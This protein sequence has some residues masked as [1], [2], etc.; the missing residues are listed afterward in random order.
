MIIATA[1]H[2]D[3]GKTTLIKALTGVNADRLAEE[4]RRGMTI[5][6]GFAYGRRN[7]LDL[8]FV[9]VPGHE[10]FIRNML[11]GV[12]GVDA[13][14]LVVAADD[15]VMPQTREHLEIIDLLGLDQGV[16]A[17]TKADMVDAER[18]S[19]V[20]QEVASLLAPTGLH[21]IPIEPV[22]GITGLGLD[23]LTEHLRLLAPETSLQSANRAFRLAVDRVFT[24]D[25][26][27]L[28]A[29][30][31]AHSGQVSVGDSLRVMPSG[32][33]VRVRSLRAHNQPVTSAGR[34][35]RIAINLAG[36]D[37][38]EVGRGDWLVAAHLDLTTDRLDVRLRATQPLRHWDAIRFCHGA[39]VHEGRLA[40][41]ETK[42]VTPGETALAQLVLENPIQAVHGDRFVLRNASNIATIAGGVVIDPFSPKRGRA[43]PERL[44]LVR[45]LADADL[46]DGAIAEL[47][48]TRNG[49]D[50]TPYAVGRGASIDM[51]EQLAAALPAVSIGTG[52]ID[53]DRWTLL[54][55]EITDFLG[56]H[57]QDH[58][59]K[60]GAGRAELA[61]IG[62][63][64]G[65]SGP[66]FEGVIN[67]LVSNR[68]LG[69][70]GSAIALAGHKPMLAPADQKLWKK[71]E[72]LFVQAGLR[73]PRVR[74][75]AEEL[76]LDP[77]VTERFLNRCVGAGLLLKVADNRYFPPALLNRL[78]QIAGELD[79]ETQGAF[80]V[81]DYKDRSEIG[82]NLTIELLE[83]FDRAGLTHRSGETR[84]LKRS[85]EELFPI[86]SNTGI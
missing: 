39:A 86:G 84:R 32:A 51:Q 62:K 82:R 76:S 59:D 8:A 41:L 50:L 23:E 55:T 9:D 43:K 24:I 58:P 35:E 81:R 65:L 49:F 6:L 29:T 42:A 68:H 21:N 40:L 44:A 78:G 33:L 30:G 38:D 63:S 34:G 26:A 36:V 48:A 83:F 3:H 85:P 79:I 71:C 57:H 54:Q 10:R 16:V 52:L 19:E 75:L 4:Q 45:Q 13:V 74:E 7:G 28:I 5:D 77:K 70:A 46:V 37:R 67:R 15:G 60:A 56:S 73:P 61:G 69:R 72:S 80:T 12:S 27:G 14:L 20:Q 22:S 47:I 31:A 1:G 25:G 18:L 11:A 64:A 2:I 17:I 66:A 53:E